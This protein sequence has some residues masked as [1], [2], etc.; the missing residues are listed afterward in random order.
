MGTTRR[1]NHSDATA[2]A[3]APTREAVSRFSA[4]PERREAAS[5]LKRTFPFDILETPE[6]YMIRGPLFG[7]RPENVRITTT[8]NTLTIRDGQKA[9]RPCVDGITPRRERFETFV[10]D[11][12]RTITLPGHIDPEKVNAEHEDGVFT[13]HVGKGGQS[14]DDTIPQHVKE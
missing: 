2:P 14:N 6:E 13:I 11:G 8:G 5:K 3:P 10:P 12:G 9:A 4:R 1:C 7:T